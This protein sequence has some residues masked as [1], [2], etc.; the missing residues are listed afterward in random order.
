M[1][2]L[3]LMMMKRSISHLFTIY[4]FAEHNTMVCAPIGAIKYK[5]YNHKYSYNTIT[6]INQRW[7]KSIHY[8]I[9]ALYI[10]SFIKTVTQNRVSRTQTAAST[11]LT[12]AQNHYG[13][14]TLTLVHLTVC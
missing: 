5:Q 14:V 1:R 4:L 11:H 12:G 2:K 7:L 8:I 10:C 13:P 9:Y 6:A 3:G